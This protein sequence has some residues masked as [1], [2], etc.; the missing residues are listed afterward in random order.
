MMSRDFRTR[1]ILALAVVAVAITVDLSWRD[2]PAMVEVPWLPERIA[3]WADAHDT[4]RTAVPFAFLGL[5]LVFSQPP[6]LPSERL[7]RWTGRLLGLLALVV[8]AVG[9]EFAQ[10]FRPSR[11]PDIAD[12]LWGWVGAFGGLVAALATRAFLDLMRPPR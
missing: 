6:P 2:S 11:Q 3:R 1:S 10:L 4:A 12:I 7:G 9:V 8:L 5:L